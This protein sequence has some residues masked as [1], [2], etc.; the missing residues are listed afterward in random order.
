MKLWIVLN[1]KK[2]II[3][4]LCYYN[5]SWMISGR[6]NNVQPPHVGFTEKRL[7]NGNQFNFIITPKDKGSYIYL[8]SPFQP[9]D[10][11]KSMI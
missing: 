7:E 9:N 11:D 6:E 4:V 10:T 1:L 5:Y 3:T 8:W 2:I